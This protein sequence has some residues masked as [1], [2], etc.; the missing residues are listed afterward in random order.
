MTKS[1]L[2]PGNWCSILVVAAL[3]CLIALVSRED[4]LSQ[5]GPSR[6][7]LTALLSHLS[8]PYEEVLDGFKQ[9][10]TG[11]GVA[12]DSEVGVLGD[13]DPRSSQLLEMANR[14]PRG[15]V[16]ALGAAATRLAVKEIRSIPI[17]AGLILNDD[18][19]E[20]SSNATGVIL[21][22]PLEI[23]FQWIRRVLPECRNIGVLYN[24]ARNL[25]KIQSAHNVAGGMGF[26]L[27]A[28]AVET[29]AELPSALESLSS[30]VEALWGIPDE[31]VFT[32]QTA[33]SI[34]LF[35]FRN[36]I[37]LIGL[38]NEWVKAG[39]LYSLEWDYRDLGKQC[40]ELAIQVLRGVRPSS[41]PPVTPRTV[42][43]SLNLKT[44]QHM[45]TTIP[46]P[47]IQGSRQV[48]K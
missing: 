22:F 13:K 25:E 32:P 5:T 41:I 21:D 38:S 37:P 7:R 34:L 19:I 24:P 33:K 10:V 40:G 9:Y 27:H 23:Q 15:M 4:A 16:L 26:I 12:M 6:Y 14:Q 43:Y 2:R 17:V 47:L 45:K 28:Q 18:D 29:P 3:A 36:R 39:A 46:E 11:Q 30:R 20:G 8:A 31:I 35:S 44:A 42:V 1:T 48:F